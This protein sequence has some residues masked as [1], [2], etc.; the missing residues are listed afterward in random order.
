MQGDSLS[1]GSRMG[2]RQQPKSWLLRGL[3]GDLCPYP[4]VGAP[5][6]RFSK[7]AHKHVT[8]ASSSSCLPTPA[9]CWLPALRQHPTSYTL[10]LRGRNHL[11]VALG[12]PGQLK[13]SLGPLSDAGIVPTH[14]LLLPSFLDHLLHGLKL[15]SRDLVAAD[16][17]AVPAQSP[18]DGVGT[19]CRHP[20]PGKARHFWAGCCNPQCLGD[21]LCWLS[22]LYLRNEAV[23]Q[24]WGV[25]KVFW[26]KQTKPSLGSVGEEGFGAESRVPDQPSLCSR[27][28]PH[29][30]QN[31]RTQPGG[32]YPREPCSRKNIQKSCG[33]CSSSRA[34]VFS[35]WKSPRS[36]ETGWRETL[37]RSPLQ[38]HCEQWRHETTYVRE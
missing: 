12:K 26:G 7:G 34:S 21:G 15:L 22:W 28:P 38:G 2:L 4:S 9:C 30:Q 5:P 24:A 31:P 6:A 3:D 37:P 27:A 19:S 36:C 23:L 10:V 1:G 13:T 11:W 32:F 35:E 29:S 14:A 18:S 16:G 20:F 8:S 25:G 17:W 33:A